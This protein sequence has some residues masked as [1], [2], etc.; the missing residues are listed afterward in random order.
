MEDAFYAYAKARK[1]EQQL[2]LVPLQEDLGPAE[3]AAMARD[4]DAN[5]TEARITFHAVLR[6]DQE[7][8][9]PW[10]KELLAKIAAKKAT[11]DKA[12][13][14]AKLTY[15]EE[16]F[17]DA[18]NL[19]PLEWTI[20]AEWFGKP[21][22]AAFLRKAFDAEE[23]P[24]GGPGRHA[25][26]LL[27]ADPY[28]AGGTAPA[29]AELK[30]AGHE[31]EVLHLSAFARLDDLAEEL[32][33]LLNSRHG[34]PVFLVSEGNASAVVLRMLDLSP[35]MRRSDALAGWINVN[36][37]LYG[38][39]KMP[40][41]GRKLASIKHRADPSPRLELEERTRMATLRMESLERP[42]PLGEGFPILNLVS[43]DKDA[44]FREALV[45][46]SRSWLVGRGSAISQV[47]EALRHVA[48]PFAR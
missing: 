12:F 9:D 44:N 7:Q 37:R 4:L 35:R 26:L 34:E 10:E 23:L 22:Q 31:V 14:P 25:R 40:N 41:S 33:G 39:L 20:L 11:G 18:Q 42:T 28:A 2:A 38:E 45:T 21:T 46:G 36:G 8:L 17:P 47:G 19:S 15:L 13:D 30:K 43:R 24:R 16:T 6:S 32:R 48:I 1:L 27:L 3:R 29:L 5:L